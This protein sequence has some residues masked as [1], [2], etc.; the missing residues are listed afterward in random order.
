MELQHW[1]TFCSSYSKIRVEEL[2]CAKLTQNIRYINLWFLVFWNL[3]LIFY[4]LKSICQHDQRS[5][6]HILMGSFYTYMAM[7]YI[8]HT[9]STAHDDCIHM[10]ILCM[11][12]LLFPVYSLHLY[13]WEYT[14][15]IQSHK[16]HFRDQLWVFYCHLGPLNE[17]SI[18]LHH[19]L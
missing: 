7:F 5:S 15:H 2:F 3:F 9:I 13:I 17:R 4:F 12:I 19:L 16:W 6:K 8:F 11:C 1:E 10:Y 14:T 18:I